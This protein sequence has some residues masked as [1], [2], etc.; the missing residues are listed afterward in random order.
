MARRAT[1]T[2]TMTKGVLDPDLSERVDLKHYF[3]SLAE[4]RNIEVRPQGG[5]SRRAGTLLG[6]RVRRRIE[7]VHVTASAVTVHNGGT[8]AHLVDQDPATL[9]VTSAVTA[10]P[11]VV[12]EFD[13][14][15]AET[16]AAVDVLGVF[17]ATA[18]AD[19]V[20]SVQYYNGAAWVDMPGSDVTG[21]VTRRH[22]RTRGYSAPVTVDLASTQHFKLEGLPVVD[23]V[24][25]VAGQIVLVKDHADPAKNGLYV[26]PT[27]GAWTRSPLADTPAEVLK[28]AYYVTGG[29]TNAGSTWVNTQTSLSDLNAFGVSSLVT[30]AAV[31]AAGR[32]RR[33]ASRPG[34]TVTARNYR[35][36]V[37]GGVGIGAV[38]LAGV[39]FWR[40]RRAT[41]PARVFPFDRALDAVYDLVLTARNVDVF[42]RAASGARTFVAS[43]AVPIAAHQIDEVTVVQSR[44]TMLLFHEDVPTVRIVRQGSDFEWNADILPAYNVPALKSGT[45]FSGNQN[46]VQDVAA[47]GFVAGQQFVVWLGDAVSAPVTYVDA[48][49]LP[50]QIATALDALPG[51]AAPSVA[52]LDATPTVRITFD[53]AN[54]SRAW[55]A[56]TLA[57]LGAATADPTHTIVQQGLFAGGPFFGARTGWPRCG[58]FVQ[59]RLIV[60]GFRAAPQS[61]G[62]SALDSYDFKDDAG[63][64]EDPAKTAPPLTADM[65]FFRTLDT[66]QLEIIQQVFVGRNLQFF[67]DSSEWYVDSRTLDATQPAN[68]IRATGSG[69]KSSVRAVFAEGSTVIVQQGGRTVRDFMFND[70]EQS[71]KAEPLSLLGPHLLTDVVDIAQRK[72]RSTQEANLLFFINADGSLV[73]LSL[74][75]TQEVIAMVPASTDG[76]FR[77][78]AGHFN[79]DVVFLVERASVANGADIYLETR[80]DTLLLDAAVR[81]KSPTPII[82]VTGLEAHEGKPVWV[83]AGKQ[84]CGPFTVAG[85][86]VAIAPADAAT[87]L[88]AG[89]FAPVT[90]ALQKIRGKLSEDMPFRPPGRIYAAG[91]ALK[92]TGHLQ[93]STNGSAWR[94]LPLTVMD[95]APRD[96]G[97][98]EEGADYGPDLPLLERLVTGEVVVEN[99]RGW[100]KHPQMKFRQ[101]VPAPLHVKAIRQEIAMKG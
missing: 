37:T 100:S 13:L 2:N 21:F 58:F 59:G 14:G 32:N 57:P 68:A 43:I 27:S 98:F 45:A 60:A 80:D 22:V 1:V 78:V 42:K 17:A 76:A 84:L 29:V 53:G 10:T 7:P 99:L 61:W 83:Y 8:A 40:E 24:Q 96:P 72:A 20:L 97:Q 50:A 15:V 91:F 89:L 26:V 66:D 30:Y 48:A 3:D 47:P 28:A 38:S 71:Y 74:L 6:Q 69:I 4:A 18:A 12:A 56:I 95:G 46:E 23:E 79:G 94:D 77:A 67:T 44:D 51:V 82:T 34:V 49:S 31:Q 25:T 85:G 65:A 41:S 92:D 35:I 55:P 75:R 11:F 36:V 5:F 101:I 19:N 39:R 62:V 54:G 87:E 90:G 88:T 86:S 33:F 52:L 81:L 9:F 70:V 63:P 73:S 93:I 64:A 16:I